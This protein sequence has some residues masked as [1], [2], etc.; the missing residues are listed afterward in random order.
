MFIFTRF[1]NF[2]HKHFSFYEKKEPK[3]SVKL[4]TFKTYKLQIKLSKSF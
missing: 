1:L 3:N 2:Y 4:K